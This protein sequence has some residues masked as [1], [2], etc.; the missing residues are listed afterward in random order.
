MKKVRLTITAAPAAADTANK[1]MNLL[2]R[3][4]VRLCAM[5]SGIPFILIYMRFVTELNWIW[6]TAA[7]RPS[8]HG[9]RTVDG[10]PSTQR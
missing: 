9:V 7:L 4:S 3:I 1:A 8:M 2:W 6:G 5:N 10:C